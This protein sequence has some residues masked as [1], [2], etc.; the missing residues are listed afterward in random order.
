[1]DNQEEIFTSDII[2]ELKILE[3]KT[4]I[5]IS[6]LMNIYKDNFN[7]LDKKIKFELRISFSLMETKARASNLGDNTIQEKTRIYKKI[8]DSYEFK[9]IFKNPKKSPYRNRIVCFIIEVGDGIEDDLL[10]KGWDIQ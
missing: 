7:K 3:R 4:E 9:L 10:K 5:P 8:I 2:E 6:K 1:M